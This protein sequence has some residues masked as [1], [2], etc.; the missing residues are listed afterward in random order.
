M[1]K[2]LLAKLMAREDLEVIEGNFKTASFN[3]KDRVLKIPLLKEEFDEAATL[4]IGHEVGHALFTPDF[5]SHE[6]LCEETKGIPFDIIN[7]VEDVRIERKV[8][9][10]YPGLI[11]DFVKGYNRLLKDDFFGIADLESGEINS[12]KF[13]DR[14]NLKFKLASSIDIDFSLE[15]SLMMERVASIDTFNDTIKVAKELRDFIADQ[16]QDPQPEDDDSGDSESGDDESEESEDDGSSTE[17]EKTPEES[18]DSGEGDSD[19]GDS[20]ASDE[21]STSNEQSENAD[22]SKLIEHLKQGTAD[23]VD[24]TS[25]TEKSLRR[26]ANKMIHAE[27]DTS[28]IRVTKEQLISEFLY[29]DED[30]ERS[31]QKRLERFGEWTEYLESVDLFDIEYTSFIQ[32]VKPAVNAMVQQF[33]LRKSAVQSKKVRETTSGSIDVNKLWQYKLDDRIFKSLS[34]VPDDKNHGL[35]MF[36]DYSASMK[37][38]LY[39]TLKQSVILSMFAKRV[40]IPFELYTFTTHGEKYLKADGVKTATMQTNRYA[41]RN[42]LAEISEDPTEKYDYIDWAIK[43][44][45]IA[46][47]S[48]SK[49]Q[50]HKM[51]KRAMFSAWC[52]DSK[53]S[54]VED[55]F[56]LGGTPLSETI[57]MAHIMAGDFVKRYKTQKMNIV[58]LTDGEAQPMRTARNINIWSNTLVWDIEGTGRVEL[59]D[60]NQTGWYDQNVKILDAKTV[61][62]ESLRKKYNVIGFFLTDRRA[63]VNPNGYIVKKNYGG[64]DSF[65][66]VHDKRLSAEDTGFSP[67]VDDDDSMTDRKRMNSIKRDFKKYQKSKKSN[68]LIAQEFARLVS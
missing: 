66:V 42:G 36:I 39:E 5:F 61:L 40:G 64:Y 50:T 2:A 44:V 19:D 20:D 31:A 59:S 10:F 25:D 11:N 22:R 7:I 56:R 37:S 6:E 51:F 45:K 14:L 57:S 33:E 46:D 32:D 17:Y 55:A 29:S 8:R 1:N 62:L 3:P 58:F 48:W 65:I 24:F 41:R 68:K 47:A 18:D 34:S 38:R 13:L 26:N 53:R 49:S 43:I 54:F 63:R 52:S 35:L 30:L 60:Q 21:E 27:R 28:L 16:Q 12:L 9:S 4:F 67:T 23:D 15:E